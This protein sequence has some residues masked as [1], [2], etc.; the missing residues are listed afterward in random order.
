MSENLI[1]F[2]EQYVAEQIKRISQAQ[3]LVEEALNIIRKANQHKTWQCEER[4]KIDE[5]MNILSNRLNRVNMGII[6]TANALGRGFKSFLELESRS[7]TQAQTLSNNLVNNNG[8]QATNYKRETDAKIINV[9]VTQ[10]P[11]SSDS[12]EA[13]AGVKKFMRDAIQGSVSFITTIAGAVG[14][15]VNKAAEGFL[16]DVKEAF[17]E[18]AV[19]IFKASYSLLPSLKEP[20]YDDTA[21]AL[22]SIASNSVSL[23]GTTLTLGGGLA[24]RGIKG[25]LNNL[26]ENTMNI[27]D[28]YS[29]VST[30]YGIGENI[31]QAVK[32]PN[33]SEDSANK[34]MEMLAEELVPF[35]LDKTLFYGIEGIQEGAK[36]GAETSKYISDFICNFLGL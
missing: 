10:V 17:I 31:G 5:S 22:L 19:N 34:I 1:I 15:G 21:E 3:K 11:I 29:N 24:D 13:K 23:I 4:Y 28:K 8:F 32:N 27:A 25:Q 9:P 14:N 2:D 33:Q 16:T 35:G 18:P 26:S 20:P 36:A 12:F 7:E 6:R 30:I